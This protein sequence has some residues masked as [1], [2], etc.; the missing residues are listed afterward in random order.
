MWTDKDILLIISH[1]NHFLSEAQNEL[2]Q[3]FEVQRAN[4]EQVAF[5]LLREAPIKLAIVDCDTPLGNIS[6]TLRK[7]FGYNLGIMGCGQS[8]GSTMT[9]AFKTGCDYYT[10][11]SEPP[12][13]MILS[14]YALK[15]RISRTE[16]IEQRKSPDRKETRSKLK[17]GPVE[18]FPND[19]LVQYLGENVRATP[20]QFKLLL[21]FFGKRDELLTRQWLQENIWENAEISQR[22]I[23]AHISKL[24]KLLPSLQ[25][26]L[27]NIYGKGYMLNASVL[28]SYTEAQDAA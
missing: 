6:Q 23:D 5:F 22:S 28:E 15:K 4:T 3:H 17:I 9:A 8:A 12:Q 18:I 16:Q 14:L 24:K 10:Q 21:A 20:T 2:S 26:S 27:I 7:S 19:Y 11:R 13:R 1:N 25:E